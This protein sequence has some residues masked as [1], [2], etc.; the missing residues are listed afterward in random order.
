MKTAREQQPPTL[1]HIRPKMVVKLPYTLHIRYVSIAIAWIIILTPPISL[2]PG[3][4]YV[5]WYGTNLDRI[6]GPSS[7]SYLIPSH[8]THILT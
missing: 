6:L 8:P 7:S 2:N 1:N 3:L 4:F 5:L